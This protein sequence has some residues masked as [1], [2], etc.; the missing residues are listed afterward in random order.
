MQDQ[1]LYLSIKRVAVMRSYLCVDDVV[2][3]N[4]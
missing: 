2:S 3:V 1:Q 4:E